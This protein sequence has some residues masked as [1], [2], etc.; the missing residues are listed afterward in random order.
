MSFRKD[1][2]SSTPYLS[3]G[4]S[5]GSKFNQAVFKYYRINYNGQEE[6][7]FRVTLTDCRITNIEGFMLDIKNT[8]FEKH[9]HQ[10]YVS[11]NYTNIEWHYLDGNI[12]HSH[13]WNERR[14]A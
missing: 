10:E 8:F 2:D 9:S 13:G 7:Y 1:L 12:I 6:E 14:T 11:I 5:C 3:K 4:V